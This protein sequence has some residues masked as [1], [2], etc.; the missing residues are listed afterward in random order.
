MVAIEK[1]HEMF[2]ELEEIK[3]QELRE[4]TMAV[5]KDA[6]DRGGWEDMAG[7]PFTLIID[8]LDEDLIEHTRRI[9]RS[10]LLVADERGDLR[11]DYVA[12]G[13]LLHDVG[14][15]ME[16]AKEG[17]KVVKSHNGKLLRHPVSGAALAMAHGM[18][19]EITHI[20]AS[21]SKEEEMVKRIPEA[22]LIYHC[23]FIDFEIKKAQKG[24]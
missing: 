20:I 13:A 18:P 19:D 12:A 10:A 8:D 22:V 4:K 3:D 21:H 6:M 2:P 1:I 5:W 9:T 16:F 11:R 15:A 14:K 24:M 17:D 7:V 23:D